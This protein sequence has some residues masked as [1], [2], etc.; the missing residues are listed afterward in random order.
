MG[1]GL[2]NTTAFV[3]FAE[4][5]FLFQ[6]LFAAVIGN[7]VRMT[8]SI[9]E[10]EFTAD[11]ATWISEILA[12]NP[13]LPFSR[14]KCEQ[15]GRGSLKRRDLTLLDKDQRVVLT[16]EVKLPYRKNG[17]SPYNAEF[18]KDARSKALRAEVGFF[19]T[20]NVNEFV[21]WQITRGKTSWRDQNYKS[22]EVTS[23]HREGQLELPM[24]IHAVQA[25]L[26]RFLNEFAQILRGTAAIGRKSPDEKF[27]EALESSLRMPILLNI[28]EL[29]DHYKNPRLRSILDKWMREE[30]GWIIYNDPERIRENLERASKFACYA[31]VNK[32]V[33]YEALLK[34][35][36]SEMEKLSLPEHIDTGEG[37]RGHLER[38]F[39]LAKTVTGDYETVFGEDHTAVGNRIPF[40][41]DSAVS[42]WRELIN[43][44]HK[45]DFSKLDY[46]IIGSIF[47]RLISPEERRKFGQFYTRVEVVD[48]IN[49]FCI[50]SGEEKVLDPACGGGT[51]LVRAYARKKELAPARKH[52]ERLADLFGVDISHFATHLTT[53]N[54]ATRDLIDYE[55]YPQITRDDFFNVKAHKTFLSLPNHTRSTGLGAIQHRDIEIPSVD[56]IIGNPPYVRQEEIRK[57][58]R[59]GKRGPERGTK[60]YYQEL[61]ESESGADLSG[62]SDIHCYFWPH[63]TSF[64]KDG[65]YLC[66]L[67]SSQWLDVEYGFKLQEWILR[68][69]EILAVLESIDEP[70]FLGARVATTVTILRRQPDERKRMNSTVRFVQLR[71]PIR[72]LLAHDGTNAGAVCAADQF[73]DEILNLKKNTVNER[74]RARLVRQGD[75]WKQGVQLGAIM[76]K[77]GNSGSDNRDTQDGDYYGGKWGVYL[78]APDLWFELLDNYGKNMTPLGD[79]AEVRF[80]VKSG[81]DCFFFPKDCTADCLRAYKNPIQFEATFR[82]P[83]KEVAS[84]KVKLVL[85]GEER[86]EIRP[87]EAK[88]L[89]PEIHSLMEVR[90]FDVDPKE[91][92]RQILLVG[93]RRQNIKDKHVLEY[94]KWGERKAYHKG[95]TCA[96]RVTKTREWYDLTGHV[97][98]PALWPKERQYRHIAPANA[99]RL[100]ANCRLYK[101][102]P[103]QDYDN[104][105]LWGG[106]LNSSWVLLSSLQF[107][108]PVG[109]EGNWSTMVADVNM[110]LVPDPT[111]ATQRQIEMVVAAFEK[112]KKRKA[113]YFLSER[114][115]REMAYRSAGKEGQLDKLSDKCELDMP[116]RRELDDA[117]LQLLGVGSKKRRNDLIEALYSY[118]RDFFER[119]RQKEE[120]AIANKKKAKRRGPARPGEIAAQIYEQIIEQQ[121]SLLQ[122]YDPAFVDESKPFDTFEFPAEGEVKLDQSLFNGHGIAFV[123]GKKTITVIDTKIPA[124]DP[125]AILVA[126]SGVRGFVRIPHEEEECRRVLQKYEKFVRER[127][128]RLLELIEDRTADEEMQQKIYDALMPLILRGK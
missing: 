63:A 92:S 29:H 70:W 47:E 66:F 49:S 72:E 50:R 119:T 26:P 62:R 6:L 84:G 71:R 4:S 20:W 67:T 61:A 111:K 38:F 21:L 55:N 85:C 125:L 45:F 34:R 100:I 103:P 54:L 37:L 116:D 32:L 127:H 3:A 104:P 1:Q 13:S 93:K 33:F 36:R 106:T 118:L 121:A 19:F 115:L 102:L 41:S 65:G 124:Q 96:G 43:Q 27:I 56:A 75:L 60:E 24:T 14:A 59:K 90:G 113:L 97:R 11:V 12:K 109:T 107:G 48:L 46:E 76:G 44:I 128:R 25:W 123:K 126:N 17:G 9:I 53:I 120:K 110:M 114:R 99:R 15:R 2:C 28:A 82:V 112:L 64:L 105:H 8:D 40:Y 5:L 39:A 31:L 79:I 81:K 86:G 95:P 42:H 52:G 10:P 74:Y 35:H 108:R 30:Q 23:V 69:F 94:I 117:V 18:V 68:N 7:M 78:R 80:G 83:R 89:E 122:Q 101:I 51:F 57:A 87:I 91:C 77:S 73:R 98:A 16:G 88:Y 22:W 58:K